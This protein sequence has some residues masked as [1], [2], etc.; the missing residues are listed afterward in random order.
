MTWI[1]IVFVLTPGRY[2]RIETETPFTSLKECKIAGK[3]AQEA[4]GG[5]EKVLFHCKEVKDDRK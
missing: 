5:N 4:L 1:L 2:T 3:N